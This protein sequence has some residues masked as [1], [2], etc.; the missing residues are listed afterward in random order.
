MGNGNIAGFNDLWWCHACL[1]QIELKG[2]A[3]T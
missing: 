3:G 2:L 1:G